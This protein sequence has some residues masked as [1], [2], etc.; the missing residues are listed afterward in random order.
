MIEI[1]GIWGAKLAPAS[2]RSRYLGIVDEI[3]RA[4]S[5][6]EQA[7]TTL[8]ALREWARR[9]GLAAELADLER[10]AAVEV[11]VDRS[12]P[13]VRVRGIDGFAQAWKGILY[14][15]PTGAVVDLP[16]GFV[17]AAAHPLEQ[18]GPQT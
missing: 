1:V 13:S 3:Q 12:E 8:V 11:A 18:V 6:K 4:A 9:E 14:D 16:R 15:A 5:A 17:R 2:L 7:Q 10:P